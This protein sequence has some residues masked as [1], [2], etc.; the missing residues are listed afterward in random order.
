MQASA[1]DQLRERA[2]LEGSGRKVR[3]L[4]IVAFGSN[5]G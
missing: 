1:L 2:G 3:W 4:M 5:A